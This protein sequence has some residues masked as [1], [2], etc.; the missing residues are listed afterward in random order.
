MAIFRQSQL[1]KLLARLLATIQTCM[2]DSRQFRR[3]ELIEGVSRHSRVLD[4][5]NFA[6]DRAKPAIKAKIAIQIQKF[7]AELEK[8]EAEL[9]DLNVQQIRKELSGG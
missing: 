4:A 2:Q 5:L 9:H 3:T 7:T 1:G 8:M 6:R